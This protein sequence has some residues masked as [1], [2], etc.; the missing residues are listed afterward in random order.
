M[1]RVAGAAL[2]ATLILH[3]AALQES[4][5]ACL[6]PANEGV[7]AAIRE[8]DYTQAL[9]LGQAALKELNDRGIAD[10]RL[11]VALGNLGT[12]NFNLGNYVT[13]ERRM[14]GARRIWEKQGSMGQPGLVRSLANLMALYVHC[15]EYGKAKAAADRILA[16][17]TGQHFS[18]VE[19]VL[20]LNNLAR[21][22]ESMSNFGGAESLYAEAVTTLKVG[23]ASGSREMAIV[24]NNRGSLMIKRHRY[25]EAGSD[26]AEAL[27]ILDASVGSTHPAMVEPLVNMAHA[28]IQA[29]R[30]NPAAA[31]LARALHITTLHPVDSPRE[32]QILSCYAMVLKRLHRKDEA[33]SADRRAKELPPTAD[34]NRKA[35]ASTVDFRF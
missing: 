2:A 8:G 27:S 30:Y 25:Q 1:I 19:R 28:E 23:G 34:V 13:A 32:R 33:R 20:V 18:A 7:S 6:H 29:K 12:A 4:S 24:L 35:L 21:L 22:H 10:C 5:A 16:I 3:S 14:N 26:F 9:A 31:L 11:A 15:G 17:P